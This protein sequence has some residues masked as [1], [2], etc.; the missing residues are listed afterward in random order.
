MRDAGPE[1]KELIMDAASRRIGVVLKVD[2]EGSEFP[3][4]ESIV[5]EGLFKGIDA[6]MI[7]WHKWW[8]KEK[9]QLDL[10]LPLTNAGFLVFDQTD[11]TNKFAGMLYA[12][13]TAPNS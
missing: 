6:M 5:R 13:R 12:V 8:S 11:P 1:L 3:I 4:F 10:I 9:T 7:E 2:C